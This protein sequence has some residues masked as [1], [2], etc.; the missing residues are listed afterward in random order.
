MK[1]TL[2]IDDVLYREV[3]AL[4]RMTGSTIED[5]IAEGLWHVLSSPQENG[6]GLGEASGLAELA[7]GDASFHQQPRHL[8]V[9]VKRRAS[10]A[11]EHCLGEVVEV[12]VWRIARELHG[13]MRRPVAPARPDPEVQPEEVPQQRLVILRLRGQPIDAY[14]ERAVSLKPGA[15][16]AVARPGYGGLIVGVQAGLSTGQDEPV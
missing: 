10:R 1:T 4:S 8:T 3:M 16:L 15:H 5:L 2:E 9:V 11:V 12:H 13:N 6:R 14:L 7:L